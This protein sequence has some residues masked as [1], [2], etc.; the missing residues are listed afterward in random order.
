VNVSTIKNKDARE[1]GV[2][3]LCKQAID[4]LGVEHFLRE[5]NWDDET[6]QLATAHIISRA[7]YPAS[8]L[9]TVSFIKENSA[10]CEVTGFD[11]EK[12]TKDMLY[13]ISHKL[14]SVK[15]PLERYLSQRTNKLFDLDDKIL[16]YDL[17]NTY[18]EG[19]MRRSKKGVRCEHKKGEDPDKKSGIY[20]LRTSLNGKD[21]KTLWTIYNIICEIEYTFRALKTDLDLRPIYH[22]SDDAY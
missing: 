10:V 20:F 7:V 18:F 9:K 1:I 8:E 17:T 14:Y 21:E 6:I 15:T 2:E 13:K 19:Q 11:K 5:Q 22:K 3:W 12:I 4:Q 16:I